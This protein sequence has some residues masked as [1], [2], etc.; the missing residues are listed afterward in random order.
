MPSMWQMEGF[1]KPCYTNVEYPFPVDPPNVPFDDNQTG[2]Y[3]VKFLVPSTFS[4]NQL[5]LRFEGVD[6]GFHVWL[7]GKEI[8]YSQGARNPSEFDITDFVKEGE[9]TLAVRVYQWTDGTYIE[10]QGKFLPFFSVSEKLLVNCVTQR[11]T[12]NK[13]KYWEIQRH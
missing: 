4:E 9:N 7:N 8:G 1:G 5:R 3:V 6:S 2:S 12:I 11:G 10:D 13:I